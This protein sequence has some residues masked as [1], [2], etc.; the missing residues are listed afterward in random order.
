MEKHYAEELGLSVKTRQELM[1]LGELYPNGINAPLHG[2]AGTNSSGNVI[3]VPDV[4]ST[5]SALKRFDL[6]NQA[7][8]LFAVV[9]AAEDNIRQWEHEWDHPVWSQGSSPENKQQQ[10]GTYEAK[11]IRYKALIASDV[12]TAAN[13][14]RQFKKL[15]GEEKAEQIRKMLLAQSI[16][17][18]KATYKELDAA[19][20]SAISICQEGLK[21]CSFPEGL[22][23]NC[24]GYLRM[25]VNE[26]LQRCPIIKRMDGK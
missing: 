22:A 24:A 10:E 18:Q 3:I 9:M 11:R 14:Y 6:N 12:E 26:L 16:E 4:D 15:V 20:A 8:K 2:K 13:A 25:T 23:V 1:S 19:R 17:S 21:T 7:I 5:R